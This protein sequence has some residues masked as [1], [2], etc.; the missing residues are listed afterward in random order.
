MAADATFLRLSD[1]SSFLDYFNYYICDVITKTFKCTKGENELSKSTEISSLNI[2]VM[3]NTKRTGR[4]SDVIVKTNMA[5]KVLHL[6]PFHI[7][8]EIA[9]ASTS[10]VCIN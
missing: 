3:L 9:Y 2:C 6:I 8:D 5:L 7:T 4:K 10:V 1:F